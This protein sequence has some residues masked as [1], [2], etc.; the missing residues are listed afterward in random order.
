MSTPEGITL[1]DEPPGIDEY[2][3]MRR[4]AGLSTKTPE[5][6]APALRSSWAWVTARDESARLVGMGRLLGDGGWYFQVADM[7]TAPD[8]QGR[9]IGRA[10]LTRLLDRVEAEAPAN[11]YVT[12]MGDAPGR[13]LY[14]SMGF[15]D[16]MPESMGMVLR[17]P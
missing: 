11:P 7:A 12:L 16:A 8:C 9:G 5:Q 3:A 15:V 10:V 2:R 1:H 13:K 6:A 14:E 4:D 17:R